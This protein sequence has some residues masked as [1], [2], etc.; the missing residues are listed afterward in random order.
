KT[1]HWKRNCPKYMD[2]KKNGI[3]STKFDKTRELEKD[4][5]DLRVGNGAKV[6]ALAIGTYA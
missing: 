5:V 4:E 3:E 6:A 1:G 2:D